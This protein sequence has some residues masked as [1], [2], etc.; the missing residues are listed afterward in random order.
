MISTVPTHTNSHS[1][2][3]SERVF[4]LSVVFYSPAHPSVLIKSCW[5]ITSDGC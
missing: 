3:Y 4:L 1:V 2:H 5:I